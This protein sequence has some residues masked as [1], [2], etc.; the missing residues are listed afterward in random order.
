MVQCPALCRL[1]GPG[2]RRTCIAPYL[3]RWADLSWT[4]RWQGKVPR[5]KKQVRAPYVFVLF[6]FLWF[7]W[8]SDACFVFVVISKGI[9]VCLGC[10][11]AQRWAG[12][13]G[14]VMDR[15]CR[16]PST[17]TRAITRTCPRPDPF[18]HLQTSSWG[19]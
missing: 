14:S 12:L 15:W 4:F 9:N 8:S 17:K 11:G 10:S 2:L 18:K 5:L 7:L 6:S 1:C 19:T 13:S 3:R 16:P